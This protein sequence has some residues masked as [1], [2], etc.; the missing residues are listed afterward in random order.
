MISSLV[1][2][3]YVLHSA[4]RDVLLVFDSRGARRGGAGTGSK[5]P[6]L[7]PDSWLLRCLISD[8]ALYRAASVSLSR[9]SKVPRYPVGIPLGEF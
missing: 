8:N 9:C 4:I 6:I 1:V 2:R 5:E 3:G 7:V